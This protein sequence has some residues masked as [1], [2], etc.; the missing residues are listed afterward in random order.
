MMEPKLRVAIRQDPLRVI[1]IS[2]ESY[3][4]GVLASEIYADWPLATLMAQAVAS[5]SYALY[6]LGHP[7]HGKYDVTATV[8]DQVFVH[9]SDVFAEVRE[10]VVLT[11]GQVLLTGQEV[12]PAFFHSCCGGH[13]ESAAHVWPWAQ[14]YPFLKGKGDPYCSEC[15]HQEW[16][17]I[18]SREELTEKLSTFGYVLPEVWFVQVQ[19]RSGNPRVDNI[20][21]LSPLLHASP[22]QLPGNELRKVLGYDQLKSTLFTVEEN[23][24][25]LIFRGKGYGHGVGM[26][27]WGA[28]GMALAGR[29]YLEILSYYYPETVIKR[30]Y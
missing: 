12:I 7:V 24:E 21:F 4:M 30:I 8:F 3:L 22:I 27:Q 5:R 13:T 19:S 26:C 29:S 10:A 28:R 14:D 16:E 11:R 2:M 15:K 18:I 25:A 20:G 23:G 9:G 17:Y 6:R 1:Q